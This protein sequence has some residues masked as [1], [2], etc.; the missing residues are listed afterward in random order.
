MYKPLRWKQI[1]KLWMSL[2]LNIQIENVTKMAR[3]DGGSYVVLF[4]LYWDTCK[5]QEFLTD[6][7]LVK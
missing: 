3:R 5:L 4:K 1:I 7:K 6:R 2:D